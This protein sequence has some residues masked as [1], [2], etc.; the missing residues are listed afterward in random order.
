VNA[1]LVASQRLRRWRRSHDLQKV[2][3]SLRSSRKA[4]RVITDSEA[5]QVWTRVAALRSKADIRLIFG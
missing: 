3:P 1:L 5:E 4:D 2:L